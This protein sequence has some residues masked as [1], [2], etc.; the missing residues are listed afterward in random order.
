MVYE[1]ADSLI[2]PSPFNQGD[3]YLRGVHCCK[4]LITTRENDVN[5]NTDDKSQK[6]E[7]E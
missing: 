2:V 1:I 4:I 7:F 5:E 3:A 6:V